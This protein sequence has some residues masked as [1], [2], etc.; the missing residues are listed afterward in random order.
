LQVFFSRHSE[1]SFD[2]LALKRRDKE[3]RCSTLCHLLTSLSN[4]KKLGNQL[5]FFFQL[6]DARVDFLADFIQ[7]NV[8]SDLPLRTHGTDWELTNQTFFDSVAPIRIDCDAVP[9]TWRS[10]INQRPNRVNRGVRCGGCRRGAPRFNDRRTALLHDWDKGL[11]EP[12]FILGHFGCRF[13]IN[14][15]VVKIWI[16]R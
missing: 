13:A 5:F 9:I 12:R 1:N 6:V 7:R 11:L 3:V 8:L 10:R 15:G 14:S 4:P 16:L 2:S